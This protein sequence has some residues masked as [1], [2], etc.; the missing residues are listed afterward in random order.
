M[1]GKILWYL[2]YA[3][4]RHKIG[5]SRFYLMGLLSF[6]IAARKHF[7]RRNTLAFRENM[8]ALCWKVFDY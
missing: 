8:K 2:Y 4:V 1:I 6:L 3:V 5:R 7:L